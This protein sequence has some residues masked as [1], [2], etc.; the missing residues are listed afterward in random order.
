MIT[1]IN[2]LVPYCYDDRTINGYEEGFPYTEFYEKKAVEEL[3]NHLQSKLPKWR[4][5]E[6]E[7]PEH[8]TDSVEIVFT[9]KKHTKCILHGSFFVDE[10]GVG[11][12]WSTNLFI[13][14]NIDSWCYLDDLLKTL[15]EEK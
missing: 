10:D 7:L 9:L 4:K 5:A 3:V 13:D 15:P 2:D 1:R 8:K 12:F 6:D 11:N 14:E